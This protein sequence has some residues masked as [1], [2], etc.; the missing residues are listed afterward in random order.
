MRNDFESNYL[1]HHGILGQKH[2]VRNG[3]PY[4]LDAKDHSASEKKAGYKK[5]LGGGR[6][7]ELYNAKQK[8]KQQKQLAK[9]V[10]KS[11]KKDG[12]NKSEEAREKINAAVSKE[13]KATL[14]KKFDAWEKESNKE[15]AF[16]DSKE[17]QKAHDAAYDD[18]LKWYKK[19]EPEQL[20]IWIKDNGGKTYGLAAYH[21]F[22]KMY[23]GYDDEYTSK[24]QESWN[25]SHGVDEN[26]RRQAQDDFYSYAG[27]ITQSL[28]GKYGSMKVDKNQYT[29]DRINL[30]KYVRDSI[31]NNA[32][33][34][35]Y[36]KK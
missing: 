27:E 6:N 5:S 33:I 16:Y 13:Q 24:A 2:G 9:D 21:D 14:R 36:K 20:N 35:Y 15:Y 25:K 28:V 19:N 23:E 11:V 31:A 30:D 1:A 7:E 26:K 17:Y 8:K 22:R 29:G 12:W 34:E 10:A 32:M 3:P 18:T 4:P